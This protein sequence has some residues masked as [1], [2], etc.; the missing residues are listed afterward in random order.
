[1]NHDQNFRNLSPEQEARRRKNIAESHL[2]HG[3][4]IATKGSAEKRLYN[5]WASMRQRC[6]NP[7][8][9]SY[10]NYGGRGIHICERWYKF[11]NFMQDVGLPLP[12]QSLDR[13]DNNG[14]YCK[15]NCRWAS[16]KDQANN[17]RTSRIL[18]LDGNPISLID[19][20]R[21]TGIAHSTLR[22]RLNKSGGVV[23]AMVLTPSREQQA[24]AKNVS[25]T[26]DETDGMI[27][28]RK[29]LGG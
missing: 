21:R 28:S 14:D 25:L 12:G 22:K 29:G 10:Q 20:S 1:M 16:R 4:R 7:K 15:E 23:N 19:L 26:L 11:E 13:I 9:E 17:R 2:E 5:T 24:Q 18:V 27:V 6:D 3:C 8:S